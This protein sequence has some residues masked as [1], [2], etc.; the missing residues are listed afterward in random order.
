MGIISKA[1]TVPYLAENSTLKL[2]GKVKVYLP[3]SIACYGSKLDTH[4]W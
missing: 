3:R 2:S 4:R 1:N